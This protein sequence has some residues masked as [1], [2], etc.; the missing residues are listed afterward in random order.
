MDVPAGKPVMESVLL[1]AP[2]TALEFVGDHLV[3]GE[4]PN[5]SVFSVDAVVALR[6]QQT[7]LGGY[8]IHG[9]KPTSHG[10]RHRWRLCVFGSKGLAVLE[11]GVARDHVTLSRLCG[12]RRLHDWIWDAQWQ[13]GAVLLA[14]ALGHNSVVLYDY[15]RGRVL[16][17]VH[18]AEKCVLY[19]AHF[20]GHTWEE[21]TLISGTVFNQLVMWRMSGRP[22]DEG[23]VEPGRRISGHKGVIFSIF[24]DECNGV[25]ASASDDRSLRVWRVRDLAAC[26]VQCLLVLYGH[27]SRVWSVR[28][29]QEHVVSV[30]EDSACIVWSHAGDII[31]NFQGHKGRGVRAV[32]VHETLGLVAT[33]GADSGIRL[34]QIKGRSASSNGIVSL[35][36]SS[37]ERIGAAKALAMVGTGALLVMTDAGSIYMKDLTSQ[38]WT[39]VLTADDNFRSYCLLDVCKSS[40]SAL[41]AIGNM[42]GAVRIFSLPDGGDCKELQLYDGKVHS[43]TW[44]PSPGLAPERRHLFSSGPHGVLVWLEVTCLSGRVTSVAEKCR[45]RL[46][47]CKQRWHTGIAFLPAE[48]VMVCGDRRGSLM[49]FSMKAAGE[50]PMNTSRD[51][52]QPIGS[53]VDSVTPGGCS[54]LAGPP[55]QEHMEDPMNTSGDCLQPIGSS[56]DSDAPGGCSSLAGPPP[57]E[58]MEDP[59]NTSGDC[60]QPIGSSVDSDTPGGCSSLAGPPPQ[61]HMEDPMNTSGDCLQPISSSVDSDTPGGCSSLAG[62]P[63][64]EHMEDPTNTSGDCLQPIGS[65]VDLDTPG[66]CSSLAGPPPQEHMEDPTNTSGDCLQPIGSSV[67]SDTP[68]GCSSLAGPPPQE[69]M[70]DPT[71]T[72]GDC[73]QPIGSSVDSDTPGGC[74]SLAGSPPQEHVEDPVFVLYG[75]HGKLGV[76]SVTHHGGF[77]YSTGRDGLYRQLKVEGSRLIVLRKLKSCKGME[78]IERIS[79][80]P[81]LQILGFHSID[82]VVWSAKTN[83]RLHCVPCGGGHRSWSYEKEG[84][85]EVFAFIKSGEIFAYESRPAETSPSVMKEPIHGRQL[86]CIK[87]AGNVK[88]VHILITSSEDTTVGVFA[89]NEDSREIWQ[90]SSIGDHLSSVRTMALTKTK[91][92]PSENGAL[93]CVL[94]TAGGRAQIECYRL[95]VQEDGGH[96]T[97]QVIHLASHRLDEHWDRVKNRHRRVKVDP[98][99][100][101]MS[102]RIVDDITSGR[103]SSALLLAAACSDGSV[104]M[105]VMS[106]DL[107][108]MVLVAETFYLQRCVLKV[109]TIVQRAAD[110]DRLW[111]CSAATDGRIAFW[112]VTSTVDY[113][114]MMLDNE[115]TNGRPQDLGSACTTLSIHQCGINSLHIRKT[116]EGHYLLASGGDDNSIHLCKLEL[117]GKSDDGCP[118][119]VRLLQSQ[120]VTS[121]HAAQ[122]TGL[123]FLQDTLMASASIDQRLTLWGLREDGLQHI[124]TRICHVTDVSD[125]EC[126]R[127]KEEE[128]MCVLCGQGLEILVYRHPT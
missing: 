102:I 74:S 123:Y 54:S 84:Q 6:I 51:C 113:A 117:E 116:G 127:S 81:D 57:Q 79:F 10:S 89:F 101:Y 15:E 16:Q 42:A 1:A 44:V 23:R 97:C 70:E 95:V 108:K 37:P 92:G 21:L 86:T 24:Y 118:G 94:F 59:T 71:N 25:L 49:L 17:E 120:S 96:V 53:S 107:R 90:L 5:I 77:V 11:L 91:S 61:E 124:A 20:V 48:G 47:A 60:L 76:T 19:S 73:L 52:L 104:R 4:G 3:A 115:C 65:S 29:L 9:I 34:W 62:S 55:P 112:D 106:E 110:S 98:E 128:Y 35:H 64:Q 27:Q 122:I 26:D 58:H 12:L 121:A 18:C 63:P 30:G 50:D 36:F 13:E 33:G 75:V 80:T 28:L 105:F 14:L 40:S 82:F 83:E 99:T 45:F 2:I 8:V 103:S 78:W 100:R 43:L 7:V 39:L 38:Q 119:K 41:C 114:H 87:Y 109:E 125:M 68:G 88:R 126:W 46:P 56:V 85:R 31:H 67:D 111:L 22:N 69:H 72:S 32:A 93:S 66:G